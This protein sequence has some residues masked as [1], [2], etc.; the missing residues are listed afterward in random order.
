MT[1]A[2][3]FLFYLAE[4][5]ENIIPQEILV[6][7]IN[8]KKGTKISLLGSKTRLKWEKLDSGFKVKIPEELRNNPPSK[9]AWTLKVAAVE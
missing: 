2:L 8:P 4:E 1:S 5:N 7:S 9:Y 3:V 6:T